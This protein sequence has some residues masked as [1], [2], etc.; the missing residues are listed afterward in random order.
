MDKFGDAHAL[1]EPLC[2]LV[3]FSLS[4]PAFSSE[5]AGGARAHYHLLMRACL[6]PN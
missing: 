3:L 5:W 6:R 4:L 1:R 2:E